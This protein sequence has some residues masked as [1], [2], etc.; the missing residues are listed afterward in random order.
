MSRIFCIPD[1]HGCLDL[2][3]PLL[4][5][6]FK[7]EN[8]DLSKDKLIFLGDMVDRGP[9]SY[10]VLCKVKALCD[11]SSNVI[12]LMGNH[13][14]MMVMY[15][16]RGTSD[17]KE[18]WEWNGGLQTQ[19]SFYHAGYSSCPQHLLRWVAFLPLKHEEP[20]YFFSHA[21]AP[22]ESF[23]K[24]PFKGGDLAPDELIWTQHPDEKGVARDHGN[25]II[26]VSG[27]IHQLRKGIRSPRLYDHHFY[28]DCGAGCSNKA[29]LCAFELNSRRTLYVWPKV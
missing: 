22:R 4:D 2:L 1:I 29:P 11:S 28:L 27:H 14:S 3:N 16:A 21:P 7:E 6:L 25:G 20:G 23:R 18:L 10:G 8:L 13:E 19:Q 12:A 26:G 5:R 9:D 24:Y 15:Y 17:D